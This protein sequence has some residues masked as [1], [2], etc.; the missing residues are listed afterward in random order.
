MVFEAGI[1]ENP[2]SCLIFSL[3]L[4]L[5][6]EYCPDSKAGLSGTPGVPHG[7]VVCMR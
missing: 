6:G 4:C 5:F 1:S 2:D 3:L 7:A